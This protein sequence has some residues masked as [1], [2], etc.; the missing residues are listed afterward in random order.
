[1]VKSAVDGGHRGVT[2][3]KRGVEEKL[4]AAKVARMRRYYTL[5]SKGVPFAALDG[6]LHKSGDRPGEDHVK[7]LFM[8]Y[9]VGRT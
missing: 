1:M 7:F 6:S 5:P 9:S 2:M 8:Q 3:A 4:R